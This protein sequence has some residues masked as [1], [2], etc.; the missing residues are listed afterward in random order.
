MEME[1]K[2]DHSKEPSKK[3]NKIIFLS[4]ESDAQIN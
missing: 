4:D 1:L 3:S 2:S